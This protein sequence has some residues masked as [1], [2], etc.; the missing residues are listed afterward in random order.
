M[1][2]R[3]QESSQVGDSLTS[4]TILA[5]LIPTGAGP[6]LAPLLLSLRGSFGRPYAP[7]PGMAAAVFM[8]ICANRAH[9]SNTI[10][11]YFGPRYKRTFWTKV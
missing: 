1:T 3:V 10:K 6:I 4:A 7:G 5:G 2:A 9:L 11:E 8:R